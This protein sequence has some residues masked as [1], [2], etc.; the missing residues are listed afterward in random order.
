MSIP[1]YVSP[2]V[3]YRVWTWNTLGLRSLSGTLWRPGQPQVARCR[4]ST[5]A[6]TLVGR[7]KAVDDTHDAP[8]P[9]CTCGI[10]AAKTLHHLRSA[11]Y[12]R[13]GIYGEVYLWGAVVE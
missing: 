4:A 3:G 1:D 12:E 7:A 5:V 2:I 8:Q 11:G 13:Y 6:G 9:N 10:Y